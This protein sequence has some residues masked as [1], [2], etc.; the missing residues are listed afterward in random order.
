VGKRL[1]VIAPVGTGH[2]EGEMRE[3]LAEPVVDLLEEGEGPVEV[4]P[5]LVVASEPEAGVTEAP[6]RLGLGG[7][8]VQVSGRREPGLPDRVIVVPVALPPVEGGQRPGELPHPG[9]P[10]MPCRDLLRD[11]QAGVFGFE[12]RQGRRPIRQRLRRE[13]IAV[14]WVEF[15][16]FTVGLQEP[17]ASTSGTQIEV[18]DTTKCRLS[19]RLR[20]G[21]FGP[22]NGIQ[23]QQVMHAVPARSVFLDQ[24]CG[25]A[26]AQQD[27]GGRD[28]PAE[29]C[30][31]RRQ[32]D[33]R[34][35][36]DGQ[37]PARFGQ[38]GRQGLE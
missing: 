33:V 24:V 37:Q 10:A 11:E 7:R 30:G 19:G 22:F 17:G 8:V 15:G 14:R 20:V 29:Q 23:A 18:Q 2:R 26:S 27:P 34:A 13:I 3:R 9:M 12:P 28:G 5:R 1:S 4:F 35:R 6:L 21:R 31:G 25:R 38:L 36:S 16:L 32:A